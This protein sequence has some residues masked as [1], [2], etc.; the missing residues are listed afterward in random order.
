MTSTDRIECFLIHP[1]GLGVRSLRRLSFESC[2]P[3]CHRA[4]VRLEEGPFPGEW[5]GE[6]KIATPEDLA[7]P[8]WPASCACGRPF[9]PEDRSSVEFDR[10]WER[11]E[12][13]DRWTLDG[14]PPGAMYYADWYESSGVGPD[15]KHLVVVTPGGHWLVDQ[16]RHKW[17]RT[18]RPPKVSVTPSILFH[19]DRPYHAFLTDGFLV[20]C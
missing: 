16:D 7:D 14:A 11:L 6:S 12:T 5:N 19:G 1:T 13:G 4:S 2:G 8:R 9:G 3:S 18:G 10:L 20:P 17:S 15:G